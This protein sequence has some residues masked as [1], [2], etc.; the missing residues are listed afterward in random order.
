MASLAKDIAN[1]SSGHYYESPQAWYNLLKLTLE[2]HG[3]EVEEMIE[4]H[5]DKGRDF[6]H[7]NDGQVF[8]TWHHM[9]SGRWEI[10]CYKT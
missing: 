9:Q 7:Y 8:F 10:I 6:I 4:I 5:G 3:N 1:L 2:K